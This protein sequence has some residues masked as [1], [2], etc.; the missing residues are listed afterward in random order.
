MDF[1]MKILLGS[2]KISRQKLRLKLKTALSVSLAAAIFF[3][4]LIIIIYFFGRGLLLEK[5]I[6]AQNEMART[7][8][9]S[10]ESSIEKQVEVLKL[11]AN[12]QFLIDA[13]KENNL[14]Y[15]PKGEKEIKRYLMDMDKRWIEVSDEHPFL[16]EYL[17]NK[18]S[19]DL[20]ELK[21]EDRKLISIIVADR[22]GG[23]V[24]ATT[25]PSG[26][27]FF[28][29]YWWLDSYAKGH[30]KIFIGASEYDE[31]NELWYLP[32]AVPVEDQARSVIGIY[33]A[34]VNI[35][36]FFKPLVNFKI[37]QTG[38]AVLVD[39]KAYLLYH[40][41]ALPFTNKF[42][43]Y[44]EFQKTL[45]NSEKWGILKSAYFNRGKKLVAYSEVSNEAFSEKKADWYV[46]VQRD[47]NEIF[48]PL[49]KLVFLMFLIG[50]ALTVILAL[51]VFILSAQESSDSILQMIKD[52]PAAKPEEKNSIE[53]RIKNLFKR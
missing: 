44:E 52:S 34:N 37:G 7:L 16:K 47:L 13:L 51:S 27:Y 49:N 6:E 48:V 15:R 46:F 9:S 18:L 38:N 45:Q 3:A 33:Q 24:G 43:E 25:R 5:G 2:K 42:C 21:G 4:A 17:D 36:T 30:G 35:N 20:R 10:V 41:R 26:F 40:R 11:N 53:R 31:Q 23:L 29:K 8:A 39:D 50:M 19:L 12:N 1:I 28:D 32:F 22:F 14:K